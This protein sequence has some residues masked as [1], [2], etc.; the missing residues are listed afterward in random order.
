MRELD[1]GTVVVL[2]SQSRE[3]LIRWWGELNNMA[4][5]DFSQVNHSSLPIQWR[6][7]RQW[8]R[9]ILDYGLTLPSVACQPF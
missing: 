8:M 9:S 3:G 1:R 5:S 7:L 6:V 4:V 2:E